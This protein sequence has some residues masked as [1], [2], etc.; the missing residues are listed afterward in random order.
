MKRYTVTVLHSGGAIIRTVTVEPEDDGG[1][2]VESTA[3][4]MAGDPVV[5]DEGFRDFVEAM[6]RAHE[7]NHAGEQVTIHVAPAS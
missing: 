6:L 1:L 5:L 2:Y 7:R 3:E 4:N